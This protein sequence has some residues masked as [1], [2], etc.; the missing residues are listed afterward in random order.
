[1]HLFDQTPCDALAWYQRARELLSL[2]AQSIEEVHP[3]ISNPNAQ[4][5]QTELTSLHRYQVNDSL[6]DSKSLLTFGSQG[7]TPHAREKNLALL[8]AMADCKQ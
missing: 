7:H 6:S 8:A 5:S 3:S 4:P 2:L 1:M